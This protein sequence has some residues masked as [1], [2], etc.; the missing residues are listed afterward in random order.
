MSPNSS[1]TAPAAN[2]NGFPVRSKPRQSR[3]RSRPSTSSSERSASS[4]NVFGFRQSSPLSIVTRATGP[5]RVSIRWSLN[6]VALG[7]VPEVLPEDRRAHPQSDAECGQAE[8]DLRTVVEPAREL[9]HQADAR[10]GER[11]AARDRSAVR[12]EPRIVRNDAHPVAPREHLHREWL[13]QLE[14]ADLVE[15]DAG[16]SENA[17][18]GRHRPEPHQLG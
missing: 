11:M 15:R 17:L 2:T 16:L 1:I 6:V 3:V 12:V 10:G 5:A 14:E 7:T 18:R 8:A 4:P 13:V 9:C